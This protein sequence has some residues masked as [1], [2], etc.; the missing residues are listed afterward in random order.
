[1]ANAPPPPLSDTAIKKI[2]F[3]AA[4]PSYEVNQVKIK[5]YISV[6][7]EGQEDLSDPN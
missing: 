6:G 2:T 1:M 3:F 5:A 4:S 7:Q